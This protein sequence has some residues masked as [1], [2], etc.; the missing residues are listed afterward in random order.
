MFQVFG[1]I[2]GQTSIHR[3]KNTSNGQ[4]L[5]GPMYLVLSVQLP[6]S[7]TMSGHKNHL[8]ILSTKYLISSIHLV[9]SD[10]T[11]NT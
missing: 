3:W 4:E 2:F 1:L 10:T 11:Y 7:N 6:I 5:I 9:L 8:Q